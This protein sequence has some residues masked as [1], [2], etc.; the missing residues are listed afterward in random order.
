MTLIVRI[1]LTVARQSTV[2]ML[3]METQSVFE[4]CDLG[5]EQSRLGRHA[6]RRTEDS[7]LSIMAAMIPPRTSFSKRHR[8]SSTSGPGR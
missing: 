1:R 8:P 7:I 4:Q 6:H 5:S 2:G 3:L